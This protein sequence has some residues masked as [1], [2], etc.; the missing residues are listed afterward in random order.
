MLP[1][2][3]DLKRAREIAK[4]LGIPVKNIIELNANMHAD[5]L[6]KAFDRKLFAITECFQKNQE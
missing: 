4:R 3:N 6:E 1:V 5:E 2:K